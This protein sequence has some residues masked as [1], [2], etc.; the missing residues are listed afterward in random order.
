M[1]INLHFLKKAL[2][3]FSL[4]D[5]DYNFE[6]MIGENY[7]DFSKNNRKILVG[8]AGNWGTK[9]LI[10]RYQKDTPGQKVMSFT[11]FNKTK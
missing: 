11:E 10:S 4:G 5:S 2:H 6:Q 8:G 9:Q 7:T 3:N 1:S